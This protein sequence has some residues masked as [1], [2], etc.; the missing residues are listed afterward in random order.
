ML[1]RSLVVMG[2]E[3]SGKSTVG[4]TLATHL[5]GVFVEGD[6]LH[7]GENVA[8]MASGFALRDEDR[9]PWLH[10]I[11]VRMMQ[12][13]A[14]KRLP[15][16][17]CSALARRYRDILRL[18]DPNTFFVFLDGP[19]DL[20]R[21]RVSKRHHAFMPL[22]LLES[23]FATLEPLDSSERGLRV[24]VERTPKEIVDAV[25]FELAKRGSPLRTKRLTP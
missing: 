9:N 17:A 7:S 14:S 25:L 19:R 2:V 3:G 10:A 16:V 6:E 11:G 1:V 21:E 12:I 18:Y 8:K 15:V 20:L 5:N 22:S 23:Q 13:E 4:H 24:N